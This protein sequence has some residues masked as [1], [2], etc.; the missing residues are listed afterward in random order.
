MEILR[1]SHCSHSKQ[2]NILTKT[3]TSV[4]P[5]DIKGQV[6]FRKHLLYI[7]LVCPNLVCE[8]CSCGPSLRSAYQLVLINLLVL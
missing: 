8:P 7:S 4:M 6:A 1:I 3:W 5:C 2:K